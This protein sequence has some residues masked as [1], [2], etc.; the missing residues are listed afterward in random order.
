MTR[1]HI[2][3]E[4]LEMLAVTGDMLGVDG[5]PVNQAVSDCFKPWEWSLYQKSMGKW[6]DPMLFRPY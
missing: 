2:A 5:P 1:G 6:C 3:R 4:A